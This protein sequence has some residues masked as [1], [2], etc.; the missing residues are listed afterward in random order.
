MKYK[1]YTADVKYSDADQ[2]L[3][4]RV[5]DINDIIVFEGQSV[6]E[7]TAAFKE[8]IDG[9][10]MDCAK[11]GREPDKPFSGKLMTRMPPVLHR[12][13]YVDAKKADLSLNNWLIEAAKEKL[14]NAG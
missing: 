11:E 5:L 1:G 4:G 6:D 13:I 7:V 3:I 14:S 8:M 10:L 12:K 9:Y 2:A